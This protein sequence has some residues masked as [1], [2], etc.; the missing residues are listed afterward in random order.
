MDRID[1]LL[2]A[3][4]EGMPMTKLKLRLLAFLASQADP[5]LFKEFR[6]EAG[7]LGPRSKVLDAHL[8]RLS[9]VKRLPPVH[10]SLWSILVGMVR[11]VTL[12]V[13]RF[14]YC[15]MCTL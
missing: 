11:Y 6:W 13:M 1:G 7:P 14:K 3:L 10:V 2:L 4:L 12:L 9:G 15:K 5:G 8:A